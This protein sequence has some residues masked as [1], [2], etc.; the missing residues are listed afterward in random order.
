M[1]SDKRL[2]ALRLKLTANSYSGVHMNAPLQA[3]SA[4]IPARQSV[5]QARLAKSRLQSIWNEGGS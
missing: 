2:S 4:G 1:M 3:G 5:L